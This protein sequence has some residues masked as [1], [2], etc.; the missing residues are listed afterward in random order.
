MSHGW[1]VENEREVKGPSALVSG[2]RKWGTSRE[3]RP[4]FF[5][6][7]PESDMPLRGLGLGRRARGGR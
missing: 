1:A 6:Q 4:R 5:V 3:P 7:T 2:P